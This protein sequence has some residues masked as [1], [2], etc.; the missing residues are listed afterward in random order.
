MTLAIIDREGGRPVAPRVN[1]FTARFW[2]GL[3]EGRFL[4]TRCT[5]CSHLAFPPQSVCSA[6]GSGSIAWSELAGTGRLYSLTTVH[7]GPP[8]LMKDGPYH[9]A[10]VDL[11]EGVRLVTAWLGDRVPLDSPAELVVTRYADGC[12]FAARAT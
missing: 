5:R 12:S 1:R 9:G 7:A 4:A 11:D 6:C 3:A 10:I 8:A 2:D